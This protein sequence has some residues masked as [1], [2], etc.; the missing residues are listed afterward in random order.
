MLSVLPLT[1]ELDK[2]STG[3]EEAWKALSCIGWTLLFK[4]E[5]DLQALNSRSI[6]IS[7]LYQLCI[8]IWGYALLNR[9]INGSWKMHCSALTDTVP[10]KGVCSQRKFWYYS[11]DWTAYNHQTKQ[12]FIGR[13]DR[14]LMYDSQPSDKTR[15]FHTAGNTQHAIHPAL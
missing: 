2:I 13:L 4:G 8:F 15:S 11:P 3:S 5:C 1:W 9:P 12:L 14:V 6:G 10:G 7:Q